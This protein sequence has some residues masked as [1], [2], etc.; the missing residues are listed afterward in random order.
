V[1][2]INE[3]PVE[4]LAYQ[5]EKGSVIIDSCELTP[6]DFNIKT[7]HFVE[8]TAVVVIELSEGTILIRRP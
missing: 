4:E 1:E 2:L 8:G 6:T 5:I 3:T 7:E